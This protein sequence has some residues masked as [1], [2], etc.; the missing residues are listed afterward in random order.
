MV[1]VSASD[2][3]IQKNVLVMLDELEKVYGRARYLAR[4]DPM[5]ELVSCILSQSTTDANSF[6]AFT[7][8]RATF[9]TWEDVRTAGWEEVAQIIQRAGLANS[10]AKS[11]IG[12][13]DLIKERNGEIH[14]ENLREMDTLAGRDWLVSLPGVG[15][16]TASIVLCFAFGRNVIPVDTH[17][18]RLSLR[19]GV[20][21]EG[22]TLEKAH[23]L[24]LRRVPEGAA[25]RYHTDLIQHGRMCCT[26]PVPRCG[27]CQIQSLCP[28][29][30]KG[31]LKRLEATRQ[32]QKSKVKVG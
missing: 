12:C 17:V 16:K 13:L 8:L 21:P 23:E 15:L 24:L 10:K 4:F 28:W 14:L 1:Q 27:D 31:G 30:K 7:R 26:A 6:P 32:K 11:I 3:R 20:L 9:P 29:F 25:F 5:D 22:T 2:K 18:H 19:L